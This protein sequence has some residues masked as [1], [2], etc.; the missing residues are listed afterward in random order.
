MTRV[1]D[2]VSSKFGFLW[3]LPSN[4]NADLNKEILEKLLRN[5]EG[6]D[7]FEQ[8]ALK[9]NLRVFSKDNGVKFPVLMKMLR[10]ALSGLN[11]GPG[12]AEMMQLL[13]KNQSL[14]RLK[15]VI[16]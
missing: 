2:L 11:E 9:E 7:S 5:L 13:G 1:E 8:D 12:V 3:I 10:G 16:R 4:K 14:E 15:A 6:L